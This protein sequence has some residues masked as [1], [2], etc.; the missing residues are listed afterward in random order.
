MAEAAPLL[1]PHEVAS[2][3]VATGTEDPA[4]PFPLPRV[5]IRFCTQCKWMLRAA[6]VSG[7]VFSLPELSE[8]FIFHVYHATVPIFT[9]NY[10]SCLFH[11]LFNIESCPS[12]NIE[13]FNSHHYLHVRLTS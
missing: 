12:I 2:A 11:L 9:I 6:Y 5:T 13:Y 1:Q 8:S 4:F 7:Y 10:N 3:I